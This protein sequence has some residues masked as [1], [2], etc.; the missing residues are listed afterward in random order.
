[1]RIRKV[2]I[3]IILACICFHMVHATRHNEQWLRSRVV[4]L[5]SKEG[6]CS[7]EQV[8]APSGENYI[9][10]AGHCALLAHD[11][12]ITAQ[13]DDGSRLERRV[14]AEDAKSDLLL[15]EGLPKLDGIAV[16]DRVR[17]GDKVFSLTHGGN[18]DTYRTDGV[19]GE[20]HTI[21]I[22]AFFID[23]EESL[24]RC[25]SSPK[26]KVDE[27]VT[28]FGVMRICVLHVEETNLTARIQPGS[29][30]GLIAN[31]DGQLV[32]VVSAG[33]AATGFM[34]TLDDVKDLLKAY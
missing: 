8:K 4:R 30:G 20:T 5:I 11:G 3:A 16:A 25:E 22:G 27:E 7:G 21:D 10:T 1:M 13:L 23:S 32:G 15:L 26:F 6:M 34:V 9:I 33:S 17:E 12:Y 28:F 31:Q 18:W 24:S 2:I 19:V 29:S 14:I